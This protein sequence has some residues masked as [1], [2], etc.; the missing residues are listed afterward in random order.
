[1]KYIVTWEEGECI[2]SEVVEDC[3]DPIDAIYSIN[4]ICSSD[5]VSVVRYRG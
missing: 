1:M 3:S 2:Y 4:H 5:V